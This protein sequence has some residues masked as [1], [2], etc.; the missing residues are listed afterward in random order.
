MK[1]RK[2]H[3]TQLAGICAALLALALFSGCGRGV[4]SHEQSDPKEGLANL[5]AEGAPLMAGGVFE[6]HARQLNEEG[7]IKPPAN[8]PVPP[9]VTLEEAEKYIGAKLRAPKETFGGKLEGIYT[10]KSASGNRITTLAYD[11]G[12]GIGAEVWKEKPDFRLEAE[13]EAADA[14]RAEE[15][16]LYTRMGAVPHVVE[17][18]GIEM[19]SSPTYYFEHISDKGKTEV[20]S[21]PPDLQWWDNGIK[22]YVAPYK[23]G[24]TEEQLMSIA[25]SMY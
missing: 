6:E 5:P 1:P 15:D 7:G 11:N 24:F 2:R 25:K 17:V 21:L 9:K 8:I 4:T 12:I 19:L 20:W 16:P 13:H 23:L 14:K 18:A 3:L 10:D 22:Y